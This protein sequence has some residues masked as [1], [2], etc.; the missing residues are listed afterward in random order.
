MIPK[1]CILWTKEQ[2]VPSDLS[3]DFVSEISD[4]P[5]ISQ[6]LRKC[7]ECGQLYLYEY[8]DF[9]ASPYDDLPIYKTYIPVSIGELKEYF[10]Q[11]KT[12]TSILEIKSPKLLHDIKADGET[13]KWNR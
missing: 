4:I 9:F 12:L 5:K 2:L 13:V 7:K 11:E 8:N 10:Q 3:F 1:Q 6:Q